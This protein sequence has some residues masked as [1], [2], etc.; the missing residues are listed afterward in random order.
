[1]YPAESHFNVATAAATAGTP[2]PGHLFLMSLLPRGRRFAPPT[3]S[4]HDINISR[5]HYLLIKIF[6]YRPSR[7]LL[8]GNGLFW[9]ASRARS[10]ATASPS[11]V[12]RIQLTKANKRRRA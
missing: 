4:L 6:F 2:T 5:C 11:D 12:R 9:A 8:P 7:M 3:A 10:G 1:M